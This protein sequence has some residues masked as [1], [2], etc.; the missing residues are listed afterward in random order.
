MLD[1]DQAGGRAFVDAFLDSAPNA[2]DGSFRAQLT[3]QTG[4]NALFT[5]ALI[6]QMRETGALARDAEGRWTVGAALDWSR[7]PPRVE[8]IIAEHVARLATS[9]R[10]LLAAASVEGET[11]TAEVV[12]R[13]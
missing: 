1:L 3:R 4:G 12:A 11:F 7:M 13:S 10:T 8:A 5:A 2:L 9:E 6:Q